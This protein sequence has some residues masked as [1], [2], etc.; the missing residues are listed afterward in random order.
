MRN[1]AYFCSIM[2]ATSVFLEILKYVI[3]SIV[4]LIA[5]NLII[6]RFLMAQ[7]QQKQMAIFQD[8]QQ[9]TIRLRLQA[10]ERL[11]LLM[12]RIHPRNLIPRVYSPN[13]TVQ[14]LQITMSMAI[15]TE[16]EHNLSQQIYVSTNVWKT[17]QS[18]KEQELMMVNSIAQTLKPEASAK[19]LHAKIMDYILTSEKELPTDIALAIID[20]EAKKVL[21]YGSM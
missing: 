5:C 6:S 20:E 11:A 2:D 8:V 15:K 19:E 21:S 18:V 14:E 12:E 4:V 17:V 10:Y 3:P 16:Y 9:T 13:M 7:N 1:E